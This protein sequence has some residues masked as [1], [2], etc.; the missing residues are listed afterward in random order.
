MRDHLSLGKGFVSGFWWGWQKGWKGWWRERVNGEGGG[1]GG[2][3]GGDERRASLILSS[4]SRARATAWTRDK[5]CKARTSR[6]M[7]GERP[8]MMQLR[9]KGVGMPTM[10]FARASNFARYEF[11][12]PCCDNLNRAP[13]GSSYRDGAKRSSRAWR[14]DDQEGNWSLWY[15]H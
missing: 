2:G 14:K 4:W 6:C 3:R 8:E 11:T 10:R 15:I 12:D 7:F 1:R 13:L 9:R 5:S